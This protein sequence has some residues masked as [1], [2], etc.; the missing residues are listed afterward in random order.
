MP[1]AKLRVS[2]SKPAKA[3]TRP[4]PAAID[5]ARADTMT[6]IARQRGAGDEANIFLDKAHRLLTRHWAKAGWAARATLVET[7]GWLVR[8]A[9]ANPRGAAVRKPAA[10]KR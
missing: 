6:R 2:A 7:A 1:R 5:K 4:R 10:A 3:K 8:V 9:A